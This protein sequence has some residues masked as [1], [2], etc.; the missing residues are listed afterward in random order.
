MTFPILR[1][2]SRPILV[3]PVS[4]KKG[5]YLSTLKDA[6]T[7]GSHR[8]LPCFL[9]LNFT[10]ITEVFPRPYNVFATLR[11]LMTPMASSFI[12]PDLVSHCTFPLVYNRYGDAV[13]RQSVTWLDSSS[14]LSPKQRKAL[15]GLRAGELTAYCYNTTSPDRLRVISDFMNYL[16]HL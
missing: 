4:N 9:D 3:R 11:L 2:D 6:T 10:G 5:N 8:H 15:R 13:A 14:D 16:F 1:Y 12:L 7:T